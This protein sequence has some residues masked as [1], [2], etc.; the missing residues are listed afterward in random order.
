MI[1]I[2]ASGLRYH[3]DDALALTPSVL[4]GPPSKFLKPAYRKQLLQG[5]DVLEERDAANECGTC[6]E[7]GHS[8]TACTA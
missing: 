7:L 4:L 6:G 2:T 5:H 8:K 1:D 3:A